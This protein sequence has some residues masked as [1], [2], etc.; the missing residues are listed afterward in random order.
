[1]VIVEVGPVTAIVDVC[2]LVTVEAG[3]V[4]VWVEVTVAGG[5]MYVIVWLTIVGVAVVT[6]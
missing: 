2:V 1:L 4:T 3:P 6:V 5:R